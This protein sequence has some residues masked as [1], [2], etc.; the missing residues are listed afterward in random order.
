MAAIVPQVNFFNW[1]L[2]FVSY[3]AIIASF[4]A[5]SLWGASNNASGGSSTLLVSNALAIAAWGL[6]GLYLLGFSQLSIVLLAVTHLLCLLAEPHNIKY[7]SGYYLMRKTI[8]GIVIICHTLM[9]WI[10]K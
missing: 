6:L 9:L 8:T 5:G 10:I 1:P 7:D 3:S 2:F 4:M